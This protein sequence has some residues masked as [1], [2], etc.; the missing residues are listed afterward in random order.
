MTYLRPFLRLVAIGR[1]FGVEDFSFSM[2]LAPTAV[3]PGN[4]PSEVPTALVTAFQDFWGSAPI[5]NSA[6]LVTLKLNEIGTNGRYT[7]DET[8]LYD[9]AAGAGLPGTAPTQV[10][11]QLAYCVS[12][13]TDAARG[14]AHAGRFYLP[15]VSKNPTTNGAMSQGDVEAIRDVTDDLLDAINAAV[16]GY[17]LAITSDLGSGTERYV[18]NA[19]YGRV[20]DTIRS[21]REKIPEDYIQGEAL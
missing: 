10:W 15:M 12:L 17:Q 14:R 6:R 16:P 20:M 1:L 18:T 7:G 9:F 3:S 8:V 19:R 5:S 4:P 13:E 21:R 11:A 2:A